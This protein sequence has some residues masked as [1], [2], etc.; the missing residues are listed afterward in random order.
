MYARKA[1]TY[2]SL[3]LFMLSAGC[4]D[5]GS[6]TAGRG[7]CILEMTGMTRALGDESDIAAGTSIQ[8]YMTDNTQLLSSGTVTLTDGGYW[9]SLVS[10]KPKQ[11]YYVYGYM[12][13]GL[14]DNASLTPIRSDFKNGSLMVLSGV[15]AVSARDVC[16]IVG[17]QDMDSRT[18]EVNVQPGEFGYI[19][20]TAGQNFISLQL[21]HVYSSLDFQ[22]RVTPEYHALRTIH[23][24]S[25]QLRATTNRAYKMLITLDKYLDGINVMSASFEP[26]TEDM[27]DSSDGMTTIY[28][29]DDEEGLVLGTDYST[30]AMGFFAH[31]AK[32]GLKAIFT[33]D[34]YDKQGNKIRSN[35]TAE[36]SLSSVNVTGFGE[37]QT[38]KLTVVP[39]YLYMLSDPDLDN[40]T[41]VE[42]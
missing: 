26:E 34:V 21:Q 42:G 40:P 32:S 30:T 5:D 2:L 33:Y 28:E 4:T 31:A 8:M 35:C 19:G 13:A 9:Q 18:S 24:K 29:A 38:V 3:A 36:N 25:V 22:L 23:L 12:P 7:G 37:R 11:Q 41:L 39:T 10:V 14:A 15:S 6:S 20:K 27:T 16:V 1:I 17:V